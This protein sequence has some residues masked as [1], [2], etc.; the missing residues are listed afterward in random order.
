MNILERIQA[1]I[2]KKDMFVIPFNSKK[3][4]EIAYDSAVKKMR[5][6]SDSLVKITDTGIEFT[7]SK[8]IKKSITN[9]FSALKK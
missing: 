8:E 4:A 1:N 9:L 5:H 3:E 2:D 6:I 7:G